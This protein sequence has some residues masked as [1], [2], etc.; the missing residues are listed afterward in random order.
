MLHR[1]N[2][3]AWRDQQRCEHRKRFVQLL[4]LGLIVGIGLQ[5]V[6]SLYIQS[7]QQ[8]QQARISY[9]DKH[10]AELDNRLDSLAQAKED[11]ASVIARLAVVERLQ[12]GR[13]KTTELMNLIPQLIPQGVYVDK[14]TMA[15]SQLEIAGISDSTAR[16]ATMLDNLERSPWLS[17]VEMHSIVHN[18]ERF[19]KTFQTFRVSFLF[20]PS[21]NLAEESD[22]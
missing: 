16:L 20:T 22:G 3:M 14:M 13:S 7:Q 11:R 4:I 12:M 8:V 18:K 10:I 21:L 1:I 17:S 2:L 15:G 6:G 19:G 5:W 9:L